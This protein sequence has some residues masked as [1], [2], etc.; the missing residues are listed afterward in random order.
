MNNEENYFP[1]VQWSK[2]SSDKN[3][4]WVLRGKTVD[5]V[6]LL[7]NELEDKLEITAAESQPTI[8]KNMCHIHNVPLEWSQY[9]SKKT[10]KKYLYHKLADGS[11]CF[12]R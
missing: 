5:E 8:A 3:E 9:P 1:P 2:M 12:G 11:F 10:G 6:L 4:Q 7:K